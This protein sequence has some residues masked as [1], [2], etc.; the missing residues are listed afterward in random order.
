VSRSDHRTS[1]RH[2]AIAVAPMIVLLAACASMPAGDPSTDTVSTRAVADSIPTADAIPP[3]KGTLRTDDI[4]LRL[5]V[6]GIQVRMI[7]LNES[8]IR[9][10]SP[11]AYRAMRDLVES[12]RADI[13]RMAAQRGMRGESVWYVTFHGVETEARFTPT[14]ITVNS[15]GRD[16]R[17]IEI[18]PLSQ[19]F[20]NQRV[21]QRETLSA[22]Y[23]FEDGI[24]VEN[25][26]TVSMDVSRNTSWEAILRRIQRERALIRGRG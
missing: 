15:M 5:Q 23:L 12:R 7:P 22:L 1:H 16:Y 26:L 19:G 3:G 14:D 6:P 18:I 9:V 4:A 11:D 25:S 10:L 21:R 20:G 17:P 13:T 24:N 8:I 2:H